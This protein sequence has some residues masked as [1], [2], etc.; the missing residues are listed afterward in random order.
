MNPKLPVSK[1]PAWFKA[2]KVFETPV[3]RRAVLQLVDTLGPYLALGIAAAWLNRLGVP[4]YFLFPLG[5]VAGLFMVRL[6]ILFHDCCHASFWASRRANLFW[7]NLLGALTFTPFR[8]W[9]RSHG[10]HHAH[11]GNLDKRGV[12]DVWTMTLEEYRDASSLRR[13]W[14]RVYR[15]PVVLFVISPPLLFLVLQ[16]FPDKGASRAESWSVHLTS[17]GSLVF[18]LAVGAAA[19][20]EFLLWYGLPMVWVATFSGVWLFYIQHQFDPGYWEHEDK[21]DTYVAALRGSSYYRLPR[22]AQWFSGNIGFHHIHHLRPHIPNYRL[23]E[24]LRAVPELQL[25]DSLSVRQ[26]L[27]GLFLHLW[28]ENT[29]HLLTFRQAA[30]A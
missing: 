6:F 16:R 21:W 28:D 29:H 19:G 5:L 23:E 9:R 1:A 27:R 30:W 13:F 3:R 12:G 22:W 15:N 10:I 14:Y 8:S 4:W 24:C 25:P 2:T 18:A 17:L 26:S 20:W 11:N 7:G